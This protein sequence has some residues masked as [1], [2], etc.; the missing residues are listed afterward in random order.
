MPDLRT[1]L[2]ETQP[3][4]FTPVDIDSVWS[5]GRRSRRRRQVALGVLPLLGLALLIPIAVTVTA[6]GRKNHVVVGGG[7]P[8]ATVTDYSLAAD[9]RSVDISGGINVHFLTGTG[10]VSIQAKPA[11]VKDV[12]VSMASGVATI[13]RTSPPERQREPV[14]VTVEVGGLDAIDLRGGVSA[15]GAITSDVLALTTAGGVTVAFTGTV[16][17]LHL[18]GS[19]GCVVD[20]R[21][22]S[23][24][25][26]QANLSGGTSAQVVAA[27]ID[28]SSVEG[29]SSLTYQPTARV[30]SL[31]SDASSRV[32][33]R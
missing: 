7:G 8:R 26:L 20:L 14:D 11:V 29:G 4:D 21:S 17:T 27:L 13:T 23:L 18:S 5:L 6:D 2:H 3:A 31:R 1:L 15:T 32:G 22:I 30:G 9:V 33:S 16:H 19:G 24:D 12:T 10:R 25:T 28:N